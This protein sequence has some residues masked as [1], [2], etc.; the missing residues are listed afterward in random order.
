MKVNADQSSNQVAFTVIEYRAE[1]NLS[2]AVLY[3]TYANKGQSMNFEKVVMDH[4][5]LL[6]CDVNMIENID[7]IK[8]K[9]PSHVDINTL[10]ISYINS[11]NF[12][13][14]LEQFF[15][16]MGLPKSI[17]R[18]LPDIV[19]GIAYC[20]CFVCY[21]EPDKAFAKRLVNDLRAEGVACWM[22]SMDA[23][24]GK[25]I[26]KEITQKRREAN[27]MIVMCSI[28]SLIRD[29]VKKEIEEQLDEEP[30]KMI[31]ISLDNDWK[32]DGFI[33]KRG[34]RDL[35]QDL[36]DCTYADFSGHSKYNESLRRLL[37]GLKKSPKDFKIG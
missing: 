36:I 5:S 25:K 30:E 35:K 3:G 18:S 4:T 27:I 7:S 22:Y 31:P 2:G 29:G 20:N 8:H 13:T 17:L 26:W 34:Q 15:L 37:K 12:E 21:G 10:T 11:K 28:K 6:T 9:G 14:K 1:A 16:N 23:I 24:P 33:V 19:A 32:E